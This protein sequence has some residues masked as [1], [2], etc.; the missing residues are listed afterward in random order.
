MDEKLKSVSN[1]VDCLGCSKTTVY[2]LVRAGR[3]PHKRVG[4]LIRFTT[5]DIQCYLESVRKAEGKNEA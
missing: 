5:S 4:R 1:L 3:I 2:R